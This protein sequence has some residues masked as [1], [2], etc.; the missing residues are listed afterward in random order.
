[1]GDSRAV[2]Q[3]NDGINEIRS[4]HLRVIGYYR[5][6]EGLIASGA[7][8]HH[9]LESVLDGLILYTIS[10]FDLEEQL[11]KQADY[12]QSAAHLRSHD[13]FM[14][15]LSGYRSDLQAGKYTANE[16]MSLLK[17]WSSGHIGG[18]D[19][20]LIGALEQLARDGAPASALSPAEMAKDVARLAA[21]LGGSQTTAGK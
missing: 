1:M 2:R 19:L 4:Q 10:S 16:L 12:P 14:R 7:E 17:I 6:V 15:R 8:D 21:R 20:D 18:Q 11:M 3:L 13:M 9:A 5:E